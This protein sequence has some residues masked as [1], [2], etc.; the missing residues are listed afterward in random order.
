[1]KWFLK[2]LLLLPCGLLLIICATLIN[3]GEI[4]SKQE[5]SSSTQVNDIPFFENDDI[6]KAIVSLEEKDNSIELG[7]CLIPKNKVPGFVKFLY[8]KGDVYLN[9]ENGNKWLKTDGPYDRGEKC[10]QGYESNITYEKF[11]PSG[12]TNGTKF[13]YIAENVSV[14]NN[15]ISTK[16]YDV[17]NSF[18]ITIENIKELKA[19]K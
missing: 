4:G 3:A 7:F 8:Y 13:T 11:K 10:P 17:G 1:M 9:D 19:I 5:T 6:K 16:R 12:R 2:L 14:L 15:N 18:S